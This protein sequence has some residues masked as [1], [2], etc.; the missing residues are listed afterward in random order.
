MNLPA[1]TDIS[2]NKR[3][4]YGNYHY[5]NSSG[6]SPALI[7]INYRQNGNPWATNQS[8]SFAPSR[9]YPKKFVRCLSDLNRRGCNG[10]SKLVYLLDDAASSLDE[11]L[12]LERTG[13]IFTM[14]ELTAFAFSYEKNGDFD[15]NKFLNEFQDTDGDL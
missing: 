2:T 11:I 7:S 15:A 10:M 13:E 6:K 4:I 5:K 14:E 3:G 1:Y 8:A 9:R 12:E